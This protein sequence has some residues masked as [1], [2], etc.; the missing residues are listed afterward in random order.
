MPPAQRATRRC[1]ARGI[2][3]S[4][5][6]N[7]RRQEVASNL[8]NIG[9]NLRTLPPSMDQ[10]NYVAANSA[11][12]TTNELQ[13]PNGQLSTVT[14][15]GLP[16]QTTN[17]T[18][19]NTGTANTLPHVP[20]STVTSYYHDYGTQTIRESRSTNSLPVA[21][22]SHGEASF[23]PLQ[24]TQSFVNI[25]AQP[26]QGTAYPLS[27]SFQP[28][29]SPNVHVQPTSTQGTA[30]PVSNTLQDL[31][32]VQ[33][34]MESFNTQPAPVGIADPSQS[35]LLM[36]TPAYQYQP[37]A[38][39]LPH[40]GKPV[41]MTSVCTDLA[42]H[43]STNIKEK[44]WKGDFIELSQLFDN[45][46]EPKSQV[47]KLINGELQI[48]TSS[49]KKQPLTIEAWS[50]AFI[51]YMSI[52][53]IKNPSI[54]R[55]LL[56]YMSTIRS[57]SKQNTTG[58]VS[59]DRLFRQK[60]SYNP[61]SMRWSSI[62]AELWLVTMSIT[63]SQAVPSKKVCFDFNEKGFC[64]KYAC[65]YLHKCKKCQGAHSS[66]TCRFGYMYTND[67]FRASRNYTPRFPRPE[68]RPLSGAQIRGARPFTN[69][70]FTPQNMAPRIQ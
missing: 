9:L 31:N 42:L 13:Y 27:H 40:I 19:N 66:L 5:A 6:S 16:V 43:I 37:A 15:A 55:D 52:L 12:Y 32:Q 36:S 8:E 30:Y 50:D 53:L 18:S 65:Q 48:G 29:T 63:Q 38:A 22:S 62:D 45:T 44:I 47:V 3:R 25:Q 23:N 10:M 7:R 34:G 57:A 58:W 20:D 4:R 33:P 54:A 28:E 70:H 59:Y 26:G 61:D 1:R 17:S 46:N 11:C 68:H 49:Q 39:T 67:S 24:Q 14:T 41:F 69:R 2:A 56:Q 35:Q 51:I 60:L 21:L 64:S